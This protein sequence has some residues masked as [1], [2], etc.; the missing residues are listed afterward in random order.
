MTELEKALY[1]DVAWLRGVLE[2][3]DRLQ[4]CNR[5]RQEAVVLSAA[6]RFARQ[7]DGA[8]LEVWKGL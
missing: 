1:A 8:L 6:R 4:A 3:R 5:R 2:G 7:P